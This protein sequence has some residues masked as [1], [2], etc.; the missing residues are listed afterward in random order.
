MAD[1]L[2]RMQATLDE[3]GESMPSIAYL[4][5]CNH[6]R[7]VYAQRQA[8]LARVALAAAQGRRVQ[9]VAPWSVDEQ[10]G[11]FTYT[12]TVPATVRVTTDVD[13]RTVH[14]FGIGGFGH[15]YFW[16][17]EQMDGPDSEPRHYVR[18]P[19]HLDH[20]DPD[21]EVDQTTWLAMHD[22]HV[23]QVL[24]DGVVTMG[25]DE[26]IAPEQLRNCHTQ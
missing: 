14:D 13:L 8:A 3:H 12:F 11:Q 9:D 1:P 15:R 26:H 22:N 4:E 6:M 23:D 25:Y 2:A 5:L 7:D 19:M 24:C 21:L 17:N 18:L 10:P 20:V 16:Y